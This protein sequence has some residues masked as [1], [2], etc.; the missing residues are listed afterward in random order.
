[1]TEI[2]GADPRGL[3]VLAFVLGLVVGS[4]LNVV[5]Y[6]L[7][8]GE[9]VVRPR[10]RCPH[11]GHAITALE[12]VP[13]LSYLA[14]RGRCRGCSVRISARYPA[15]EL[16]T[17]LVFLAVS[18]RYGASPESLVLLVFGSLLIAAS[19]IDFEHRIIPDAISVGGLVAGFVL[20]PA[21]AWLGGSSLADALLRSGAGAALG[22]GML[23]IVG[24]AHA[25]VCAAA[26][27]S[28]PHW[29]GE[30]ETFPRLGSLDYWTWFPGM[31]FGDVKL[32]AM[33]GAFVGPVGVIESLVVGSAAGLVLG[34]AWMLVYR[35]WNA[36]FGFGPALAAGSLLV[37]LSPWQLPLPF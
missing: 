7:P 19:A 30:G 16:L 37:A 28:F 24:F 9:S 12:N 29:P 8:R 32:M 10:S 13:V 27:R 14:L 20:A 2:P 1:M 4:F 21:A 22:F 26:G 25:R 34:L 11:C 15:L 23:W 31:G 36:P 18:L 33:I 3:H 35:D 17:G 6:R 5:I